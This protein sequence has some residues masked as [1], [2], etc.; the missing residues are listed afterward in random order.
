MKRHVALAS[1]TIAAWL[2]YIGVLTSRSRWTE[3]NLAFDISGIADDILQD[4]T[5]F[6]QSEDP[7]KDVFNETLGVGLK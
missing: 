4:T 2:F 3:S 7:L 5:L 1:V 6:P